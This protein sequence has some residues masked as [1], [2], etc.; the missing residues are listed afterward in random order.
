[1]PPPFSITGLAKVTVPSWVRALVGGFTGETGS[2]G[3][4]QEIDSYNGKVAAAMQ[5]LL[6]SGDYDLSLGESE[7][8]RLLSDARDVVQ[9]SSFAAGMGAWMTFTTPR[10]SLFITDDDG[11]VALNPDSNQGADFLSGVVAANIYRT[12]F[13]EATDLGLDFEEAS[14]VAATRLI[15]EVGGGDPNILFTV[16]GKSRSRVRGGAPV[17]KETWRWLQ[18][19]PEARELAPTTWQF[20]APAGDDFYYPMYLDSIAHGERERLTPEQWL[21][22]ADDLA[23]SYEWANEI[24]HLEALVGVPYEDFPD[25]AKEVAAQI[26]DRISESFPGWN[27]TV[28]TPLRGKEIPQVIDELSEV[29][30]P[31]GVFADH[32][33]A[34]VIRMIIAQRQRLIDDIRSKGISTAAQPFARSQAT[35]PYRQA[36]DD[37]LRK[38]AAVYPSVKDVVVSVFRAEIAEGLALDRERTDG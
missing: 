37:W 13:D 36:W 11:K 22:L 6:Q 2:F 16:I 15:I 21:T 10:T 27:A 28:I 1:E 32:P 23:G 30:A 18:Q 19:H 12:Y 26:R 34:Q 35:A 24:A 5:W 25:K 31:G 20:F 4:R 17:S 14:N 29:V 33:D 7:T 38:V 8:A 3:D 9:W